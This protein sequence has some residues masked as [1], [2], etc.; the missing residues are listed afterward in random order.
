MSTDIY[1]IL[2]EHLDNLPGGYPRTESGVEMRILR[3]LF[4]PG[5]AELGIHLTI[6]PE[7]PRVVARRANIPVEEATRRLEEMEKKGLIAGIPQENKPPAYM[8][9]HCAV[10]F[11]EAQVNKLDKD[12]V[13]NFE[14]YLDPLTA[15]SFWRGVPQMR[16]IPLN[17]SLSIPD[18]VMPYE[19]GEDL[20]RAH[21]A[22]AVSNCIC[23]QEQ[24]IMGKG[25]DKPEESCLTLG[26]FA[27]MVVRNGRGRAISLEEA[28]A[29]LQ[30]AE[31][32]GLVLQPANAKESLFI[33]TCCGCCCNVLRSLKRYPEPAN[34]VASAF[35]ASLN[36]ETCKGCGLC[37]KRCQ[38]EALHLN[39]KKAVQDLNRCIGCGLCVT[40]CPTQSLSLVR[41][42]KEKQPYVPKDII[43]T[44]IKLGKARGKLGMSKL[45]GMQVR[46]K[47]DRLLAPR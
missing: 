8:A 2:A 29:I 7:E 14:E 37:T 26:M 6:I 25:C 17:K 39:N 36:T 1:E 32:A 38:M 4:T 19:R 42:P 22:F 10:G 21:K 44:N 30:R 9:L 13:Q 47:L 3:R 31:E 5:E 20:V 28:L 35:L 43:D 11:Y 12:L 18:V 16:T 27:D 34:L 41:K 40:T 45:I 23:R 33:C 46:S 24:R 15:Q